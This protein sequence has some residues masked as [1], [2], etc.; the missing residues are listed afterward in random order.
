MALNNYRVEYQTKP[1]SDP[2]YNSPTSV[3]VSSD[4]AANAKAWVKQNYC[5][6]NYVIKILKCDKL[7]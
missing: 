3:N 1:K 4:N 6:G 5:P 2:V 7:N